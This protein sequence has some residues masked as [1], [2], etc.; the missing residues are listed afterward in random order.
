MH[1]DRTNSASLKI[2]EDSIFLMCLDQAVPEQSGV[3][4]GSRQATHVLHGSGSANNS[5]NRWFD[6]TL[7]VMTKP[8]VFIFSI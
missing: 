8:F 3:T 1:L 5:G 7:Q 4:S 6:K 2:I